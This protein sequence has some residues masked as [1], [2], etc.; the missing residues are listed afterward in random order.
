MAQSEIE[1]LKKK[2]SEMDMKINVISHLLFSYIQAMLA[3]LNDKELTNPEEFKAYL[4]KCKEE[5]S[6]MSG[7]AQFRVMMKDVLPE[8][9]SGEAK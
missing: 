4:E 7:D 8:D 1:A 3:L 2:L 9:K 5:L 6:R